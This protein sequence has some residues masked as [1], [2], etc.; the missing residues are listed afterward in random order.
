[1]ATDTR[2]AAFLVAAFGEEQVAAVS[3]ERRRRHR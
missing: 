1:V 2:H 3:K